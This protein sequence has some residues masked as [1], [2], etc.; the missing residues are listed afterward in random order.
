MLI[1][2]PAMG[3]PLERSESGERWSVLGGK[4]GK[5]YCVLVKITLWME[6]AFRGLCML[7]TLGKILQSIYAL[8]CSVENE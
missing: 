4:L 7:L 1:G 2:T 5:Q 8:D 6:P 3:L